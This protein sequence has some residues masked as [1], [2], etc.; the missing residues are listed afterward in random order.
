[1]HQDRIYR[2]LDT[3]EIRATL[4]PPLSS[5]FSFAMGVA[6]ATFSGLFLVCTGITHHR[7]L[8]VGSVTTFVMALAFSGFATATNKEWQQETI[9]SHLERLAMILS[10]EHVFV[11]PHK[12]GLM[13]SGSNYEGGAIW[14]RNLGD[15]EMRVFIPMQ[16]AMAIERALSSSSDIQAKHLLHH[17]KNSSKSALDFMDGPTQGLDDPAPTSLTPDSRSPATSSTV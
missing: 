4:I 14:G 3:P 1:M 6:M 10:C 8:V 17:I 13:I 2:L 5:R 12:N 11:I 16:A 7:L 9:K 15:K